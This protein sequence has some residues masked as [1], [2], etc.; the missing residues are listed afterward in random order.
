M[1]LVDSAYIEAWG[2][3]WCFREDAGRVARNGRA[4]VI[5][6]DNKGNPGSHWTAARLV[7]NTLYYADPFGTML[8]GWPPRELDTLA[9]PQVVN[10]I[11]FQR[12]KSELCGY[13]A[14]CFALA[15]DRIKGTLTRPQFEQLLYNS[16][17]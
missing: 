9:V 2:L 5:N 12:P 3:P 14:I 4:F 13:Y 1:K 10:R 15:M 7:S 8:N 16:I 11:S 17:I 6:L